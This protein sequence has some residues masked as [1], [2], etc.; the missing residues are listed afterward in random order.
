VCEFAMARLGRQAAAGTILTIGLCVFCDC[1]PSF[2]ADIGGALVAV[3]GGDA[4]EVGDYERLV[5]AWCGALLWACGGQAWLSRPAIEDRDSST[6]RQMRDGEVGGKGGRVPAK[7]V[8]LLG[9]GP[10][11]VVLLAREWGCR[12]GYCRRFWGAR[13]SRSVPSLKPAGSTLVG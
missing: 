1:G 13:D 10:Y 2:A 12:G 7:C 3:V 9:W 11:R 5:W 4:G 8:G 6:D